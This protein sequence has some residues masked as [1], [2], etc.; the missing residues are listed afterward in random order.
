MLIVAGM[1]RLA[2]LRAGAAGSAIALDRFN[3][4]QYSDRFGK[5][6]PVRT[7]REWRRRRSSILL[8][9]QSIMGPLPGRP[10][11]VPLEII[12]EAEVDAGSH[13][14]RL[15]HYSSEPGC[16]TPAYL[17]IPKAALAGRAQAPA[18]LCLH[19][20][21]FRVGHGVVVGLGDTRYPAYASELAGRGFVVIA[22]AYPLLANYQPDLRALGY[23]SGTMKAIWDNHRALDLLDSLPFVKRGGFGALGHSLGGHNAVFTAAFDDRLKIV[24][25]SCGLDSFA[26]YAGGNPDLWKPEKGWCQLRYLPRLADYAGRL[27]DIPFDFAELIGVLAPRVC[28]LSAPTGDANFKWTSVDRI[29]AAARPVYE[30][31]GRSENLI[32]EH[33]DCDHD[34]PT[35]QRQ[36]AYELM[37]VELA[38]SVK[39]F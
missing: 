6:L 26:D 33:P 7:K 16:R 13:L 27:K 5:I 12:V 31:F 15:I 2:L 14:R 10:K 4:L 36:R 8:A 23:D 21:D 29:A 34:F 32:V 17:L 28:Y 11:R 20:T 22:P 19:P 1:A 35:A 3:L 9:A 24:V 25:S 38:G 39:L 30:L 18:V 37:A